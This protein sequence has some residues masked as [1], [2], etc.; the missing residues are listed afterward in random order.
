MNQKLQNRLS[1]LLIAAS[2]A[3]VVIIAFS[4]QELGSAWEAIRNLNPEWLVCLLLC[5]AVY[6]FF[7][8]FGCW[9]SLRQEGY[10]LTVGQVIRA[11]LTG[12]F[13]SNITPG[14]AGGQPMQVGALRR[15]G[16]PVGYGTM[17]VTIRLITNQFTVCMMGAALFA[18]NHAFVL[19]Q[20][21]GAVWFVRV[22]WAINFAVV[23]LVLLA[24]YRRPWIQ[25]LAA[26]MIGKL[27]KTRLLKQPDVTL[28]RVTTVLDHY[29]TAMRGLMRSPRRLLQQL[30]ASLLSLS[31]LTGSIVVVYHAFGLSGTPWF[32]LE[33]LSCLLFLSASYTP[34]PGASG[35]QEGGFLYYFRGIFTN[36]TIG[37]ALLTWRFVTYYLFL[38]V[39]A[40]G[41]IWDRWAGKK[42]KDKQ[43][44]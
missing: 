7:E 29:E 6:L 30:G 15:W 41:L 31:G 13:Y 5:W 27:G 22:G 16:V 26:W 3:A 4:N 39:G 9:L 23:P 14:A 25:K 28:E 34:L 35:A 40:A 1:L 8:A 32:Q 21:G 10:R 2:V 37:L 24:T 43:R 44:P 36:G 33:T 11:T 20:L 17:S 38:L 12:F 42:N 18:M 19:A